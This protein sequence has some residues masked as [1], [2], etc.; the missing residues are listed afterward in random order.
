MKVIV[1]TA[2]SLLMFAD[3]P[4]LCAQPSPRVIQIIAGRDNRFHLPGEK[5]QVLMLKAN[6][7]L[8]LKITAQR[9]DQ[10]ALDGAVHSLVIRSLRSSGWDIRLKEGEQD[11]AVRAPSL[12]GTYFAECTVRCGPGHDDMRL[13]ILVQP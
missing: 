8:L 9:G 5:K 13:K 3:A 12:P 11:V 6:E 4:V 10:S 7:P 2:W 1:Y